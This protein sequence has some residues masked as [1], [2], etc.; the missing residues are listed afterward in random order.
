MGTARGALSKTAVQLCEHLPDY[1]WYRHTN[2]QQWFWLPLNTSPTAAEAAPGAQPCRRCSNTGLCSREHLQHCQYSA[3][4]LPNAPPGNSLAAAQLV[5]FA[6]AQALQTALLPMAQCITW[7]LCPQ[8]QP[9]Q[10]CS[11][12]FAASWKTRVWQ[13]TI[14]HSFPFKG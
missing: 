11:H 12:C 4:C 6:H 10:G 3:P 13:H 2:W 8:A 7:Q 1:P 14:Q 5:C 9:Q